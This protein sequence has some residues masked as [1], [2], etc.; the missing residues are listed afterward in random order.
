MITCSQC[1]ESFE[2]N[3]PGHLVLEYTMTDNACDVFCSASCLLSFAQE[4]VAAEHLPDIL[5]EGYGHEV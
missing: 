4:L 3:Q 5:A 1:D 2:L